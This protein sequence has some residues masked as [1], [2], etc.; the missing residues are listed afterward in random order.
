MRPNDLLFLEAIRW[1][2]ENG[3][4]HLDFGRTDFQNTGLREFKSRWG[5]E[6]TQLVY[7]FS[8]PVPDVEDGHLMSLA[9]NVIRHSPLW[10]SRLSGELFYRYF[11]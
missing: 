8:A 5:A 7:S 9:H 2:S 1:G 3:Y 10:V 11:G 4:S 6:E